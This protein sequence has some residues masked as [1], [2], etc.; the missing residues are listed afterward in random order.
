MSRMR[1]VAPALSATHRVVCYDRRDHSREND[2]AG[3]IEA[4]GDT[5]RAILA[6]AAAVIASSVAVTAVV[7]SSS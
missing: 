2:L 1:F 5:L 4:A 7:A 3:L 6:E